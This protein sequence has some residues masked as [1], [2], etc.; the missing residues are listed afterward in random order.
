MSDTGEGEAFRTK[1][2]IGL[3]AALLSG[4]ASWFGLSSAAQRGIS[5]AAPA[6]SVMDCPGAWS[7][8]THPAGTTFDAPLSGE[9]PISRLR[10]GP[11]G[12][13]R[14]DGASQSEPHHAG[15]LSA[16]IV[17]LSSRPLHRL[18]TALLKRWDIPADGVG[19]RVRA[20]AAVTSGNGLFRPVTGWERASV[21]G[22]HGSSP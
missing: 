6:S 1:A 17:H 7:L 11:G 9:T 8:T 5:M 19:P 22:R 4:G 18:R 20:A 10:Q 21:G 13:F 16:P 3:G 2:L 15:S 14:G 12:L